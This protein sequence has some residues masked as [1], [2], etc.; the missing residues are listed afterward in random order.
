[1]PTVLLDIPTSWIFNG[2]DKLLH[3]LIVGGLS[4]I[5]LVILLRISGKRTLTKM[6]SF[7]FVVTV[8]F[9]STLATALLNT[10]ISI[11]QSS[12]AFALLIYAQYLI[13]WLSVRSK[14]FQKLIK[15]QPELVFYQGKFLEATMKK[16]RITKSEIIAASREQ[17]MDDFG[18]ISA[19]VLETEGSLSIIKKAGTA[20]RSSLQNVKGMSKHSN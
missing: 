17:G 10:K 1:M 14:G 15:S 16:E 11:A 6:N 9:G 2:W 13:T 4:Y 7:D 3:V 18:E 12:A 5:A 8:A 20:E 19:I